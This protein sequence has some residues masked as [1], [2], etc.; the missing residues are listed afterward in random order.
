[1]EER[2]A[3]RRCCWVGKGAET[4]KWVSVRRRNIV[5]ALSLVTLGLQRLPGRVDLVDGLE[6][7]R[8]FIANGLQDGGALVGDNLLVGVVVDD[9]AGDVLDGASNGC[10]VTLAILECDADF[11]ASDVQTPESLAVALDE[12]SHGSNDILVLDREV[13]DEV[14]EDVVTVGVPLLGTDDLEDVENAGDQTIC[15]G[16]EVLCGTHRATEA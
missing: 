12:A 6:V 15:L 3:H 14:H 13:V 1:M 11:R 7:E 10:N 2:K 4:M 16:D 5:V 9:E 8:A